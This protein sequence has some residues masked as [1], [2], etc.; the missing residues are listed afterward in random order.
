VDEEGVVVEV[1]DRVAAIAAE[2]PPGVVAQ[3]LER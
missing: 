3:R 2:Q 1:T